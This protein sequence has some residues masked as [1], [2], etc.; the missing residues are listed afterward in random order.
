MG[1]GRRRGGASAVAAGAVSLWVAGCCGNGSALSDKTAVLLCIV[2]ELVLWKAGTVFKECPHS[3]VRR[4]AARGRGT[5][6]QTAEDVDGL[7]SRRAPAQ[8]E[9]GFWQRPRLWCLPC[10][11]P[12][13]LA[14]NKS[15]E[16][17]G[18]Q[19]NARGLGDGQGDARTSCTWPRTSLS[20]CSVPEAKGHWRLRL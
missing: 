7:H 10:A 19:R 20:Q 13:P 6:G 14:P 5:D 15:E 17:E 9:G 12:G 2:E 1:A 4:P 11:V 16:G 3:P 18:A 8:G